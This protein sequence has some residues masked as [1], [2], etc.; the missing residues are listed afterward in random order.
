[1]KERKKKSKTNATIKAIKPNVNVQKGTKK[2]KGK[3][4]KIQL[5]NYHVKHLRNKRDAPLTSSRFRR[6]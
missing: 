5:H 3:K 6:S 4:I 2:E 1:M